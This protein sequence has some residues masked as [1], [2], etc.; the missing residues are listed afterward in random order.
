[1]RCDAFES[2]LNELLDRRMR[3]EYD[4]RLS[5]HA[6]ECP[7]CAETLAIQQLVIAGI[8]DPCDDPAPDISRRVARRVWPAPTAD[9]RGR[10]ATAIR[11]GWIIAALAASV[12]VA[13]MPFMRGRNESVTQTA[14]TTTAPPVIVETSPAPEQPDTSSSA[15]APFDESID[16]FTGMA[17]GLGQSV[18]RSMAHVPGVSS[19]VGPVA[20]IEPAVLPDE[21]AEH[22]ETLRP[23]A[24]PVAA[25]VD[26]LRK[27]LPR[28]SE[29]PDA[30]SSSV[31][32][33]CRSLI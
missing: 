22:W 11:R 4:A 6:C 10:R 13:A 19:A 18:A 5:A 2:R 9:R 26:A 1:M 28:L 32:E 8:T 15:T 16:P 12:T 20:L 3:P 33:L 17:R 30:R 27:S 14:L 7:R 23:L 29:R 24:A 21:L 31:V 25:V